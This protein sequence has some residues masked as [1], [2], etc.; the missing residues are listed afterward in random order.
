MTTMPHNDDPD[1]IR[2]LDGTAHTQASGT[3]EAHAII[4]FRY[5]HHTTGELQ[6]RRVVVHG[7]YWG[8]TPHYPDRDQ[9]VMKTF[10]FDRSAPRSFA[11]ARMTDIII[12]REQVP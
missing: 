2:V 8:R 12:E 3:T 11:M 5:P 1:L 6:T 9:W 4:R 7:V 10:C